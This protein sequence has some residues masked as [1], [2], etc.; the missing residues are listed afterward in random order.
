MT[1]FKYFLDFEKE[2]RWLMEMADKGCRLKI[3][4]RLLYRFEKAPPE[5]ANI[6]VDYQEFDGV[7]WELQDNF[8]AYRK[9][10]GAK[11]WEHIAGKPRS[12]FQYFKQV[13]GDEDIFPD[14]ASRSGRYKR[15]T[16][17]STYISWGLFLPA[18]YVVLFGNSIRG[19][20]MDF[21]ML[22][23]VILLIISFL[24]SIAINVQA[25]RLRKKVLMEG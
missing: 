13:S 22:L 1:K 3:G 12:G 24:F 14:A 19:A 7:F 17:Q 10:M 5:Q 6:R 18:T 21:L 20:A 4:G 9:Q 23:I 2:E 25:R 15:F 16:S 11:G 8:A